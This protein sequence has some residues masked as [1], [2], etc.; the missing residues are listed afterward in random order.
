MG[1]CFI[2]VRVSTEDQVKGYS[3]DRQI[4]ACH[5]KAEAEG[6]QVAK[7][8][9]DLGESAKTAK[10][11]DFQA[12]MEAVRK[13]SKKNRV[14]AII[15]DNLD[16]FM[17]NLREL[18]NFEYELRQL[19]VRLLSASEDI[20]TGSDAGAMMFQFKGMFAERYLENL[21]RETLKGLRG[22]A[23]KGRWVGGMNPYGYVRVNKD[24]ITP[25]GDASTEA[26][27]QIF[28]LYATRRYSYARLADRMNEQAEHW[29]RT[30]S[31]E[32]VRDILTN[33]AYCGYVSCSGVHYPG[34]H[35]AII[36]EELWNKCELIRLARRTISWTA[37]NPRP[38]QNPQTI[39][40]GVGRCTACD[41]AMWSTTSGKPGYRKSYYRCAGRSRRNCDAK[42]INAIDT[43][44]EL[45]HL[46][47]GLCL[48]VSQQAGALQRLIDSLEISRA[49]AQ[50]SDDVQA[51]ID[52]LT[53][54]WVSGNISD[55]AYRQQLERLKS[56]QEQIAQQ[57]EEAPPVLD[58]G[59][60]AAMLANFPKVL[61]EA[62]TEEQRELIQILMES[63]WIENGH[64]IK[65]IKPKREFIL[66]LEVA[67]RAMLQP[68]AKRPFPAPRQHPQRADW[69][70]I[71]IW[72]AYQRPFA[73]PQLERWTYTGR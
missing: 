30:F 61:A 14:Q 23:E 58:V 28:N 9:Q 36:S 25:A 5:D 72:G 1:T 18:L 49:P 15:I 55:V 8:Y 59:E 52:R 67:R 6:Y 42:M 43:D 31:T 48:T 64:G 47:R 19:G 10:R 32:A 56:R 22:K 26:V 3:I 21:K 57:E 73:L 34:N 37:E 13:A 11:P 54:A 63:V 50:D 71:P 51:K 39:L 16:R 17:R 70:T 53:T 68:G 66:L 69:W 45:L 27:M 24:V 41:Q 29:G 35:V 33:K 44:D 65:A 62:T 4:R 60:A 40:I 38:P 2:Y 12:M 7:V 20:D 46:V